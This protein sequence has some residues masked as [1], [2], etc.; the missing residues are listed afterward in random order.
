MDEI[1]DFFDMTKEFKRE[2][3]PAGYV[4]AIPVAKVE[5]NIAKRKFIG[6]E[7][8]EEY[9]REEL[10]QLKKMAE[11]ESKLQSTSL[12]SGTV[13][14]ID[15]IIDDRKRTESS[16][17]DDVYAKYDFDR[18]IPDLPILDLKDHILET[19]EKHSVV[20]LEGATGC[21]KT[22]Q[23]PQFILDEAH[24]NQQKVNIVVTQPRRI[25]AVSIANRVSSERNLPKPPHVIGYQIGL[26]VMTN[27]DTRITYC[28][29]GV[30][31]EKLVASK[32]L[33][34]YTHIIL[35]EVHERSQN[36][37]FLFIVLKQLRHTAPHVRIILMSATIEAKEFAEYFSYYSGGP[38]GVLTPAPVI[39]LDKKSNYKIRE[40]FL[41]DL[42]KLNDM[43]MPNMVNPLIEDHMY[44]TAVKLIYIANRIDYTD[45]LPPHQKPTV[46]VFLPGIYEIGVMNRHIEESAAILKDDN[47]VVVLHS[48]IKYEE[49]LKALRA[50]TAGKRL[51][52]L[53]TNIAESSITVPDVKYVIDFC[54]TKNNVVDTTTN[55]TSLQLEWCSRSNCRQRAGRTGRTMDGR[56]Y[57]LVPRHFYEK[58]MDESSRPEMCRCPLENVVLK[59]KQL[60]MGPPCK[61][62]ALA[63]DR[64]TM[65]DIQNTVLL[66]KETG[67]FL[68][69]CGGIYSDEDGDMTFIGHVMAV[70]PVDIHV[71]KL[72]VLGYC[73]SVL[74]ECIII[75]AGLTTKSI[76]VQGMKNVVTYY[77]KKLV[78]S[79]GSGSDLFAILKAY[80]AYVDRMNTHGT[81]RN[82]AER[83]FLNEKSLIEMTML[84][85]EITQRLDRLGIRERTGVNRAKWSEAE[86]TIILKV[87]IAG[88]FYPHYFVRSSDEMEDRE[89]FRTINGRN[90]CNTVFFSGFEEKYIRPLYVQSIKKLL[91]SCTNSPDNIQVTF[92]EGNEKVFV[93][94][95]QTK[96]SLEANIDPDL[97]FV[98]MGPGQVAIE[99]YKA[100]KLKSAGRPLTI[101][102]MHPVDAQNY[103][104]S[105]NIGTTVRG[106]F[107]CKK[108]TIKNIELLCLPRKHVKMVTGKITYY[109][110]SFNRFWLRSI[111]EDSLFSEIQSELNSL[112]RDIEEFAHHSEIE[113]GQ[114][115]AANYNGNYYRAKVLLTV[116]G[117]SN[118]FYNVQLIDIGLEGEVALSEIRRLRGASAKYIDLP[119]R[120]F[121]C[122]LACLQPSELHSTRYGW[123]PTMLEFKKLTS[124]NIVRAEIYS[125]ENGIASVFVTVQNRT[126]QEILIDEGFARTADEN[127]MSKVDHDLRVRTQAKNDSHYEEQCDIIADEMRKMMPFEEEYDLEEPDNSKR[128]I[129]VTLKG[130]KSPLQST[131][132]TCLHQAKSQSKKVVIEQNSVNSILLE[133]NPQDSFEKYV[134]AANVTENQKK[135]ELT[136]RE[137]SIMPNIPGF[138]ALMALIFSPYC[139]FFRDKYKSRY[140][141]ILCGLGEHP[142]NKLPIFGEHDAVFNLDTEIDVK[143]IEN[144]N[145]IRFIMDSLLQ[146]RPDE[147][148]PNINDADQ[149]KLTIQ[150][151]EA[152]IA[153]LERE[154]PLMGLP[155]DFDIGW[156]MFS[157]DEA[158]HAN[159][160]F[161]TKAIFPLHNILSLAAADSP[162][163]LSQLHRLIENNKEMHRLAKTDVSLR[164]PVKCMLCHLDME[165]VSEIKIHLY[166][167]LHTEREKKIS[168][169]F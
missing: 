98:E 57:R 73:F 117:T 107:E 56:V 132:Y 158:I 90:P 41:D 113:V 37:D 14:D 94:F 19:V 167:R 36:M 148:C 75:A 54:L 4:N 48:M 123:E 69:T 6:K 16:V 110:T 112:S 85:E 12:K 109:D 89:T 58:Q 27:E 128:H 10:E 133:A 81:A 3:L 13:E 152:I 64:P 149:N 45:Q 63:M 55:F 140:V 32:T 130:P 60:N 141:A 104:D 51:V 169:Q 72:I 74:S 33:A 137:T 115:V 77:S 70:L 42:T 121:E 160:V 163:R 93:S 39:K 138:G 129:Q 102:V 43:N 124:G 18:I 67:A 47:I 2:V 24:A 101:K 1:N 142:I 15:S 126:V 82:W 162:D 31:L 168:L 30:L 136:A 11:I 92:D 84:I 35:D 125:V 25:A 150:M 7:F 156:S 8:G 166:S 46:L 97:H 114:V 91:K 161:G 68:R 139:E 66:L 135:T 88:A 122:R 22:T 145:T 118:V 49:Q 103:A 53:A 147:K 87:V 99:V 120:V 164:R 59:A 159:D 79:D 40:F 106:K 155:Y 71:A 95:K 144:I 28:T 29:T 131:I 143:D 23:V 165:S 5:K 65:Y 80:R 61:I 153:L 21:G 76:F 108:K 157:P 127:F 100:L 9:R 86:K 96:A 111:D 78:W 134:I 26:K 62:I 83:Y 52:I 44:L 17:G 154:R 50:P 119:P 20:I 151:K 34:N 38:E 105:M 146:M 116:R